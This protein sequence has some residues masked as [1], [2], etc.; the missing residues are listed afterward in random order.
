M[1][2]RVEHSVEIHRKAL[3]A[4][5]GVI[6]WMRVR[7]DVGRFK[8]GLHPGEQ[9]FAGASSDGVREEMM[10]SI[11]ARRPWIEAFGW[12]E[13]LGRTMSPGFEWWSD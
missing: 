13:Q 4:I 5:T 8:T 7:F 11:A 10:F 1:R 9:R 12:R 6:G 3:T 2:L